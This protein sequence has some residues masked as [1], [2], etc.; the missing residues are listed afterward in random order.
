MVRLF[1]LSLTSR[2]WTALRPKP[3]ADDS[4]DAIDDA[5]KLARE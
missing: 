3:E 2:W 5:L 1:G 4:T